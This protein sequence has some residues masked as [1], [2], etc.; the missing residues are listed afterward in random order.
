MNKYLTLFLSLITSIS[1]SQITLAKHDLTPISDGQVLAFNT[2]V[3]PTSELGFYVKNNSAANTRVRLSCVSL[4][5]NDG[6]GFELCFGNECLSSVEAETIYPSVPVELAPNATNGNF[7]HFLNTNSG[8]G[9]YPK[10]YVFKFYQV[11]NTGV[12]FGN[13]INLTYRFDPTL[14]IDAVD[15]LQKSGVIVKSTLIDS[16]IDLDV[17][18]PTNISIFDVNGKSVYTEKL[19]YGIQSIDVS[20]LLSGVYFMKFDG[21]EGNTSTKKF[22]KK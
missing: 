13:E 18:K 3:Y 15:Q 9:V 11:T 17:L 14:S 5:N 19:Y 2:A 16:R 22:I 4:L 10:D 1:Y 21:V 6:T 20:N 7:D 8:S 12:V